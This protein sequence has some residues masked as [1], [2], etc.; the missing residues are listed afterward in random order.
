[1]PL[2]FEFDRFN[3]FESYQFAYPVDLWLPPNPLT[4]ASSMASLES[5]ETYI[6][7]LFSDGEFWQTISVSE[8][9]SIKEKFDILNIAQYHGWPIKVEDMETYNETL[10]LVV[11]DLEAGVGQKVNAHLFIGFEGK[12]SFGWHSDEGHV[13]CYMVEGSK[14]METETGVHILEPGDWLFMPEGLKHC[15]TNIEDSVMISFGTGSI[16]PRIKT[17]MY[18]ADQ[19]ALIV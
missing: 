19:T 7:Q 6:I 16:R 1:M 9:L 17:Q 15:A 4:I 10:E 5:G 8:F 18:W 2:P 13:M 12:G 14:K 3:K 11:A